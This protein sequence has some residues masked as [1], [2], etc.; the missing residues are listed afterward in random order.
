MN[1]GGKTTR[2]LVSDYLQ[3]KIP[4]YEGWLPFRDVFEVDGQRVRDRQ[5]R[6]V[7][8]F[9][10]T[11]PSRALD[12]AQAIVKE[13]A[14]Y[15]IGGV[16]RELNFPTLPLWFLEPQNTRRFNFRK[17]GEETLSGRRVIVI[18][19]TESSTRRSSRR[20]RVRTSSRRAGSGPSR[21]RAGCTGRC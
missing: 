17:V 13:S 12:N 1:A 7:K 3:V 18:E 20:R 19:Y 9:V 6:L 15:N 5:D 11:S 4:G 14:R 8:L 21:R 16:R 2:T 10:Q